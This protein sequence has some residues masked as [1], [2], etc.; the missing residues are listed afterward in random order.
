[1]PY[2]YQRSDRPQV[3]ASVAIAVTVDSIFVCVDARGHVGRSQ[4]QLLQ[5][6]RKRVGE[7][8]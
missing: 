6:V 4:Q 3:Q 7:I 1:M 2:L 8:S 5:L